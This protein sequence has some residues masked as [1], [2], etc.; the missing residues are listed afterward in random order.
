MLER[1]THGVG[2]SSGELRV[3][4]L[5]RMEGVSSSPG[6]RGVAF[7][8]GLVK[9]H[10]GNV[11]WSKNTISTLFKNFSVHQKSAKTYLFLHTYVWSV[12]LKLKEG[13]NFHDVCCWMYSFFASLMFYKKY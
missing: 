6:K 4:T 13:Q 5:K 11:F 3:H 9:N 1:N 7:C 12:Q 2:L 8:F 10:A